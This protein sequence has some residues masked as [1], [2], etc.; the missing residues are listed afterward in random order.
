M[1]LA[2]LKAPFYQG[3]LYA[4]YLITCSASKCKILKLFYGLRSTGFIGITGVFIEKWFLTVIRLSE[5]LL[6]LQL[7]RQFEKVK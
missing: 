1:L 5:V 4:T 2:M 7:E 6:V 3:I